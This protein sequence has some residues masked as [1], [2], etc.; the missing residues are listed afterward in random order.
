MHALK[1]KAATSTTAGIPE[2]G[3]GPSENE[4]RMRYK[5]V[6]PEQIRE[7]LA[8]RQR[9]WDQQLAAARR[10]KK[11]V[12]PQVCCPVLLFI[13][14]LGRRL[15]SL[16]LR[17]QISNHRLSNTGQHVPAVPIGS[18]HGREGK[19]IP[20]KSK[21]ARST[22]ARETSFGGNQTASSEEESAFSS[23]RARCTPQHK[24]LLS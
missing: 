23:Y 22:G 3:D 20:T 17:P 1:R 10:K 6:P 8:R 13:S 12:V 4:A 9:L 19:R 21:R 5:A 24:Q 7:V 15:Q 16:Q 11:P 2:K 18:T 14:V